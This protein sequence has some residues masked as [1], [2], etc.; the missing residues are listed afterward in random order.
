S[1][2]AIF[3]AV[4]FILVH[5][6]YKA[7]LFLVT[8]IVD[9]AVHTRDIRKIGGLGKVMPVVAATALV[10]SL[11]SAGIPLTFGFISKDLISESTLGLPDL[12]VVITVIALATNVFIACSGFLVGIKPFVGKL[13]KER[14]EI[15]KPGFYLWIP[16]VR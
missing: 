1:E 9:H 15:H 16:V 12:A 8:G 10:A 6:L 4:T 2:Y 5:A 11:S 13:S 14:E 3:A 7:N